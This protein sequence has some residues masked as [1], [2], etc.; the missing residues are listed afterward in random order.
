MYYKFINNIK[1]YWIYISDNEASVE[2][3]F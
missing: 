1:V 2:D 3:G